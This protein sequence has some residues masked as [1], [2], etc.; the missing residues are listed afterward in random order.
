MSSD[1]G[2]GFLHSVE[3]S[4][5]DALSLMDLPP[6]LGEELRV[7]R[8]VYQVRFPVKLRG[9]F[10]VFQGWRAT[11]S[12]H[13]LPAKGGI[14]Y[15]PCVNQEE[16]EALATLM[17]FKC[18]VVDV[19]FG[20]SKGGLRIDPGE[21]DRDEI[22]TITRR[23]TIE[24]DQKG[25]ISP[26]TNVPAPDMGTGGR[27]MAWIANTYRT[28]HPEDI[29][30]EACVTG[31]PPQMGG[32]RGR[33]EA[34]GRGVQ[35]G[36]QEFF[37]HPDDVKDAGLEG[38][39]EG[40]RIVV[41]G[42]GNVGYH[43]AKFLEEEDGAKIVG[44]IERDG[45]I[46]SEKGLPVERVSAYVREHGGV[47]GFPEAEYVADGTSVLEADCEILIPAALE[48]QI[49]EQNA[50]RIRARLIAEA[51]NGPVTYEADRALREAG[52]I[53]IPDMYLNAGGVT[54]S[55]FEWIKNLSKIRFGRMERRMVET[56][57]QAALEIFEAMLE[58]PVPDRLASGL[59]REA[60]ELNL[61]RS[62]LDDT[63][64]QAYGEIRE[65]WRTRN[66]VKDLR[67]AAYILALDK[68]AHYYVEYML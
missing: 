59:R 27:E 17:T 60:D 56:R 40:K 42:L 1:D 41:Q 45:A 44:I 15:A 38:G 5:N 66:D 12:E 34:T 31:K 68:V 36:L 10:R 24:L 61:V 7:C 13:R 25:Y 58:R 29:D 35:N 63:M 49:T 9:E 62:G 8:S 16:V 47:K 54:V 6:G 26:S 21:Y 57:S 22:E 28:L 53:V 39:L 11:H 32:I 52:R 19:P 20:G 18:A 14:R 3:R 2:A 48:S 23:F 67:T 51:A 50:G 33:V 4:I 37:R 55:Y 64:R 46:V 30:A 65:V 43:A